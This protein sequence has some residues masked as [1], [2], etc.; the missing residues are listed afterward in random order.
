MA[1]Q[2]VEEE[3][4]GRPGPRSLGDEA[5]CFDD[6]VAERKDQVQ[7][8]KVLEKNNQSYTVVIMV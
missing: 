1:G 4:V 8:R 3:I 2:H 7:A 6:L 5:S